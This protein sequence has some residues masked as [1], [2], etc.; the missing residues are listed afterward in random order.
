MGLVQPGVYWWNGSLD[1]VSVVYA[2]FALDFFCD[3]HRH[4][5][6]VGTGTAD[7]ASPLPRTALTGP[8]GLQPVLPVVHAMSP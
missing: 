1:Y 8:A 2:V 4:L 7:Y 6:D 5:P 3:P